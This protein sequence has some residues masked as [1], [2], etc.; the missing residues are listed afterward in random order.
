[1]IHRCFPLLVSKQGINCHLTSF[2]KTSRR[3]RDSLGAGLEQDLVFELLAF[4]QLQVE[5][6]ARDALKLLAEVLNFQLSDLGVDK[7]HELPWAAK[8]E[9]IFTLN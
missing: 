6:E 4:T 2:L 3:E 7:H 8:Q 1:M 5:D 9:A